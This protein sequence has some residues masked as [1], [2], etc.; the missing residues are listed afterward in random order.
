L[1]FWD[2]SWQPFYSYRFSLYYFIFVIVL[3][4]QLPFNYFLT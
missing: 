1:F 3:K 2:R 4:S